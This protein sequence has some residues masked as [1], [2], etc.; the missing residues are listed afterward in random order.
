MA[1]KKLRVARTTKAK[2]RKKVDP[3]EPLVITADG[4]DY[5]L[6]PPEEWTPQQDDAATA[7]LLRLSPQF[8]DMGGDEAA[9]DAAMTEVVA[10]LVESGQYRKMLGLAFKPKGEAFDPDD[11]PARIAFFETVRFPMDQRMAAATGAVRAFF[12][13]GDS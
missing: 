5:E 7:M 8:K 11:I 9:N 10:T 1:E 6:I 2:P 4:C 3:D 12:G 13:S